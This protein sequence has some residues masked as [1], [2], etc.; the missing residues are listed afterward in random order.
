MARRNLTTLALVCAFVFTLTVKVQAQRLMLGP[1]KPQGW[2]VTKLGIRYE[3]NGHDKVRPTKIEKTTR[4][5]ERHGKPE[6]L[7]AEFIKLANEVEDMGQ[8]LDLAF[9]EMKDKYSACGFDTRRIDPKK[10]TVTIEATAFTDPAHAG[11]KL[12]GIVDGTRIRLTVAYLRSN[13]TFPHY[14]T[15]AANEFG[16]AMQVVYLGMPGSISEELGSASPCDK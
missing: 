16:N 3:S 8:H 11:L 13:G 4:W 7:V 2:Q 6:W 12:V 10:F 15:L 9:T 14:R 5:L 1:N